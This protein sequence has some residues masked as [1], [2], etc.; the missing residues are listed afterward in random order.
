MKVYDAFLFFNELDLLE[1]RLNELDPVVDVF[2]IVESTKT[3]SFKDKPLYYDMNKDRFSKFSHKIKHVVVSDTPNIPPDPAKGHNRHK[4]EHFQRSCIDRGVVDCDPDDLIIMSDVDE[5]FRP[6][7]VAQ[8][9]DILSRQK[10]CSFVQR[11]FYY[12]LNGLCV[13]NGAPAPWNGPVAC[14]KRDYFDAQLLRNDRGTKEKEKIHNAGWHFSYLGGAEKIIEKIEAY[15]HA[16]WDNGR[17]K[18]KGA[19]E[20]KI[21]SGVDIFERPN[22]PNQRYIS[23]DASF[24][25]YVQDNVEKLAH[26]IK[27]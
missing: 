9:I 3:F 24:P 20:R 4:I 2:V 16:E 26:L 13:Q 25:K 5:I 19:L 12:Y 10:L 11:F 22:R 17:I 14:F 1:I 18:D 15:A 27:R 23:I 8:A 6:E 21:S 7:N